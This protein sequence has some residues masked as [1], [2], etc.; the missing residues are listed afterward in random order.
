MGLGRYAAGLCVTLAVLSLPAAGA[1]AQSGAA[2][3]RPDLSAY[4]ERYFD[5][6]LALNPIEATLIGDHRFNQLLG[7]PL[8]DDYLEASDHVDRRYLEGLSTFDPAR[9]DARA[10][11]VLSAF[12]WRLESALAARASGDHYLPLRPVA[13]FHSVFAQ[14]GSGD[15]IHP[16]ASA[17]DYQD[18]LAR[19]AQFP[20]WADSA[21]VNMRRARS[22]GITQACV[23]LERVLP[24]LEA[25]VVSDPLDSSFYGPVLDVP[26]VIGSRQWRA[27]RAEFEALITGTLVPAYRRLIEF[28]RDE[29]LPACRRE[30]GMAALPGGAAWYAQLLRRHTTLEV[31]AH[32]VHALGQREVA[33]LHRRITEVM[34]ETGY[35]GELAG[36]FEFMARSE[37][38][39]IDDPGHLL[40]HYAAIRARIDAE[41]PRLFMRAPALPLE[42]RPMRSASAASAP[43]AQ[44]VDPSADGSRKAV[45]YVNTDSPHAR[46]RYRLPVTFLHEGIPGHHLQTAL[47]IQHTDLPRFLRF[48][49]VTAFSEGWAVYA[50]SLGEE[51]GVLGDPYERFGQIEAELLR[52]LRLVVDT[53]IHAMGWSREQA[54]DYL[55]RNSS[56]HDRDVV[57]EVERCIALPGHG[58]AYTL[59]LRHIRA[60]RDRARERLGARFDIRAFHE[61]VLRHGTL[62][63]PV[64]EEAMEAWLQSA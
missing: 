9:L 7:N 42:I 55:R 63:L 13:G 1:A 64:L 19:A 10:R 34:H 5:E 47:Q 2:P 23:M 33:R 57:A 44:Y 11:I 26:D 32:E 22:Q 41:L 45:V 40:A 56:L 51:L 46:A 12:R 25:Q 35:Q 36:F 61:A 14:M 8:G 52:A 21:I 15:G 62:P 43:I 49:H 20:A 54:I 30:P 3:S 53:G 18:F 17:N 58:A 37:A 6:Y 27:L 28:V 29:S 50:E 16:F 38:M 24:Q 48:G 59:G 60:L 39:H 4:V 31:D